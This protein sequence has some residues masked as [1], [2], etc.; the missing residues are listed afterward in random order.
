[1]IFEDITDPHKKRSRATLESRQVISKYIE[2]KKFENIYR[3]STKIE[4]RKLRQPKIRKVVERLIHNELKS[5]EKPEETYE[6]YHNGSNESKKKK[7]KKRQRKNGD[8]Q[9]S[10]SG[11]DSGL[12]LELHSGLDPDS[13]L[14]TKVAALLKKI[15]SE[16]ASDVDSEFANEDDEKFEEYDI[17][18]SNKLEH[19]T[20]QFDGHE[21]LSR[22]NFLIQSSGMETLPV[23]V[24]SSSEVSKHITNLNTLLHLNI[25][26]RN[27]VLAYK[28]FCLLTRFPQ[29]DI[30]LIW[31]LGIEI[32][33]N[34]STQYPNGG[35]DNK[36]EK[37][38]EYLNSF[39]MITP[40]N[41][42]F[43]KNNDKTSLAPA[44]RS[45]TKTL[46][47]LYL[48]NSLWN[49]FVKQE[50]ETALNKIKELVLV[51]PYHSEGVLYYISALCYLGECC[52]V[53]NN[54]LTQEEDPS[55]AT[56]SFQKCEK[57]IQ[58]KRTEINK[59]L[60][61]CSKHKFEVMK[62]TLQSEWEKIYDQLKKAD[63]K[64]KTIG[65]TKTFVD[66]I[67]ISDVTS[68]EDDG[69]E[70]GVISDDDEKNEQED[71][72]GR[73]LDTSTGQSTTMYGFNDN[74]DTRVI[75]V[76]NNEKEWGDF[77]S[78]LDVDDSGEVETEIATSQTAK[79]NN[80]N[81]YNNWDFTI[82]T[83]EEEVENENGLQALSKQADDTYNEEA[84]DEINY[85][86]EW[87]QIDNTQEEEEEEKEKEEADIAGKN[88][89][90]DEGDDEWDQIESDED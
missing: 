90:N 56:M 86:D 87:D 18:M 63:D 4:Q 35:Y 58:L 44:W 19:Y 68:E 46:T 39:F 10:D 12:G 60:E 31:S 57:S 81:I 42:S 22:T 32:L 40:Q 2:L 79:R 78:D 7:K 69:N 13:Q 33:T 26:R 1:M 67:E 66:E 50:Y 45:G 52:Q 71:Q 59:N 5:K 89:D 65:K 51:P 37:F 28:I 64:V 38:Y 85:S 73:P 53:V 43:Y 30:R 54:Y 15:Q 36:I 11:L 8:K 3:N 72:E 74:D 55:E 88:E 34:L 9:E 6:V 41:S 47:P 16:T 49:L 14:G 80:G 76:N 17:I 25:L 21:K 27:W 82:D 24:A 29:V 84:N 75:E 48:I 70:W 77:Q 62:E 23:E 20:T 61:L 83:E